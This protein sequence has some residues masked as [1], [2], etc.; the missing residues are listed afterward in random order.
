M[1]STLVPKAVQ[2][3]LSFCSVTG[4]TMLDDNYNKACSDKLCHM[5]H[6]SK[7]CSRVQK[8]SMSIKRKGQVIMATQYRRVSAVMLWLPGVVGSVSTVHPLACNFKL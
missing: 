3:V 8:S 4:H 6:I 2:M 5:L 7:R 1:I